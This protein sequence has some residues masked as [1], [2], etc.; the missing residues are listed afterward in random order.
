MAGITQDDLDRLEERLG[1]RIDTMQATVTTLLAPLTQQSRLWDIVGK[2]LTPT[3]LVL[4]LVGL[5]ILIGGPPVAMAVVNRY[6]PAQV[7]NVQI[8]SNNEAPAE[9]LVAEPSPEHE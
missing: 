4:L 6:L 7:G 5:A 2:A 8:N 3:T 9:P 1:K